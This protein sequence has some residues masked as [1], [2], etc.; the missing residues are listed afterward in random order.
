MPIL[1]SDITVSVSRLDYQ[2][3]ETFTLYPSPKYF[4]ERYGF[5]ERGDWFGLVMAMNAKHANHIDTAD[6]TG[7][8]YSTW[9]DDVDWECAVKWKITDE[10]ILWKHKRLGYTRLFKGLDQLQSKG[11]NTILHAWFER[12][13]AIGHRQNELKDFFGRIEASARDIFAWIIFN[14]TCFDVSPEGR[15]DL[16]ENAHIIRGPGA[17][18]SQFAVTCVFTEPDERTSE[19]AEFGIGHKMLGVDELYKSDGASTDAIVPHDQDQE[20]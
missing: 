8:T 4:W 5:R 6:L 16:I 11:T 3:L 2:P 9:L 1:E 17:M 7:E 10:E 12:D 14:E 20:K 19:L 15:F 13:Y 18:S